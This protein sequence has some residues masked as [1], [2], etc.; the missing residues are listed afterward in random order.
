MR[1][2]WY[3][4]AHRSPQARI[5]R[6]S[7]E[8]ISRKS[9]PSPRSGNPSKNRVFLPRTIDTL[10]LCHIKPEN[11]VQGQGMALLCQ[12]SL[13]LP[14]ALV[15]L[16]SN[17]AHGFRVGNPVHRQVASSKICI[18]RYMS[19][20]R[21]DPYIGMPAGGQLPTVSL[22]DR[23]SFVSKSYDTRHSK[24]RVRFAA[25]TDIYISYAAVQQSTM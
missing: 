1:Y 11:C 13:P 21:Y 7:S 10:T 19:C 17:R 20:C 3:L 6:L 25:C 8:E 9:V 23:A 14:L 4:R 22:S 12:L 5:V 2:A 18:A 16:S 15:F 24:R